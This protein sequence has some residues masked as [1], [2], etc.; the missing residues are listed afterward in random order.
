MKGIRILFIFIVLWLGSFSGRAKPLSDEDLMQIQFVQKVNSQ[1]RPD[2]IFRDETGNRVQLGSV[3]GKKPVIMMLGY[4]GC[5][6]LCTLVLNGAVKTFQDLKWTVGDQ[7]DVV[8][9]SIDPNETPILADE[10]K[11]MYVRSYGRGRAE[12]WHFLTGDTNSIQ[13]LAKE[14]GFRFAYDSSSGQFAHPSGLIVLSPQGKIAGYLFGVTYSAAEINAALR[15]AAVEKA[16][17][18][19]APLSLL[20][21]HYTPLTGKYGHLV[22]AVVRVSGVITLA[23]LAA[24]FALSDRRQSEK[25]R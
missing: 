23:I 5:P 22:M 10:K 9:V 12:G 20:C 8:F 17:P 13:A 11:R 14:V 21:F 24:V 18:S 4:Y 7:F 15:N 6:M 3:F 25:P 2:L 1:I 16:A 19:A